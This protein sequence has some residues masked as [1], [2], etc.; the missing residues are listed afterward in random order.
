MFSSDRSKRIFQW[1]ITAVAVV[2]TLFQLYTAYDG[3]RP[4]L[5]QRSIHLLFALLMTFLI[6]PFNRK[7]QMLKE[8]F[9]VEKLLLS[10][11]GVWCVGYVVINHIDIWT[12]TNAITLYQE[13]ISFLIIFLVLEASRRIT[14]WALPI[15]AFV[16]ISYSFMGKSLPGI[17]A[18][19]GYSLTEILRYQVMSLEGIFGIALGVAATFVFLFI[20]YAAL[21]NI[22]GGGQIFID[23]ATAMVGRIRGGPAK[24]AVVASCMF[25]SISGSAVANVAGT[26]TFTIP[27]MKKTGYSSRFAGAVEAVSSSGGQFMPPIMGS[28]AFLI[29]EV[30]SIPFW[31]VALAAAFPAV[32]YFMAIFFMVDLEAAKR[33]I[34]GLR[35]DEIP[36]FKEVLK[37][38]WHLMLSPL[39][40]VYLLL[41]LQWSPMKSAFWAI[42]VTVLSTFINP[43]NRMTF[44]QMIECMRSGCI[45]AIETT[46][47][48][49]SVG[50][51]IGVIM[52]T[53]LG[54][55]MSSILVSASN[56]SLLILLLLTMLASLILGM[57]LPTVAAY[58][59]L[60]VM[61]APALV[62]MGVYPLAAHLFIFYFGIISAITPPVA[63]ASFVAAGISGDKPLTT[64]LTSLRLG[65]SAFILPF[66][67]VYGPALVLNGTLFEI[68]IAFLTAALGIFALSVGLQRYFTRTLKLWESA[69]FL[70]G[71]VV[72]IVP[73]YVSDL[74]GA[75]ILAIM[76]IFVEF[77]GPQ[78]F[79][80]YA[81]VDEMKG[82]V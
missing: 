44:K 47:A 10:A 63:L 30:L 45:G 65:M 57:G 51:V 25:G 59:V 71:S 66:A 8:K 46:V 31:E 49:A 58:L 78:F 67:F 4:A 2:W 26:G 38:G 75:V 36:V 70:A 11:A 3:V 80:N 72:L 23:L 6:F 41:F 61:V 81:R 60:G 1:A 5:Q 50:L 22:S 16:F 33:G 32:L 7:N 9:T 15:I 56:G 55:S 76:M 35:P 20:F 39:V 82:D 79:P 42:I 53:G 52:Q 73:G 28:A 29:A 68:V 27:L 54:F 14:G 34:R 37:R 69:V 13:I 17:L 74:V 48:C 21:L 77:I 19:K 62:N 40:L 43:K 24:I 12:Q 64:S 18:H